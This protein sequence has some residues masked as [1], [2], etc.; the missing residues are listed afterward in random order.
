ML[1]SYWNVI[2]SVLWTK[3]SLFNDEIALQIVL[4]VTFYAYNQH[5]TLRP[6]LSNVGGS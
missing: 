3:Q 4:A 2:A 1:R 6:F 5:F